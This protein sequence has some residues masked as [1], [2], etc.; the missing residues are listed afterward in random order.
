MSLVEELGVSL[1]DFLPPARAHLISHDGHPVA[2]VSERLYQKL[3]DY[4]NKNRIPIREVLERL[5]TEIH[6]VQ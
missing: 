2:I 4:A 6:A 1:R 3:Q 5:R